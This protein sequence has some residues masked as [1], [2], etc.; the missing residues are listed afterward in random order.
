MRARIPDQAGYVERDSVRTYYEVFGQGE[1]AVVLLPTWS[2]IHSR[3][4]KFQVPYL[5]R[6]CKVI[7]FDGRGNGRSDRP[8]E[9]ADYVDREFADDLK[10]VLLATG[11]DQ[12]IL[13]SLSRAANW[14]LLFA[15]EHPD[16]VSGLVFIGPAVPIPISHPERAVTARFKEELPTSEGWAKYNRYYWLKDHRGFLEYFFG[17]MFNE[18]HSTKQI[19]DCVKWGLETT[20]ATLV[21]TEEAQRIGLKELEALAEQIQCPVLVIHGEDDKIIPHARGAALAK[22][23]K[24][25]LKTVEES[26]HGVMARKPVRVN[27]LLRDFITPA[28]PAAPVPLPPTGPIRKNSRRRAKRALFISSPIGLGHA[29]RDIAI[30]D[31]LRLLRPDLE[32]EWLA[33]PPVTTAL[34]A[35]GEKIHPASK[36][37]ACE[38]AHI[39][40]E[41]AEHDLHCFQAWRQMDE[42][43]LANFMVFHDLVRE[44]PF[45]LWI[46]DEAWEL[47]YYLHEN[48][49]QKKAPYVWL[50]D[51]VGWLPMPDGG[52]REE[53]LTADYN[54]E[55]VGHIARYPQLRDLALFVGN[56][57]D[58]IPDRF[59]PDLPLIRDWT[60]DHYEFPGYITGFQP[61]APSE[62]EELRRELGYRPDEKVCLVTVGGSGVGHH[63]LKRV[64]AAFPTAKRSLPELR[65]IV[66][67]GPRIDPASLPVMPGLEV[68]GYVNGLY[69]HLAAADLAVVQGGLSTAME[70]TANQRPFL[71]FP[72]KHHFEQNYHVRYRLDRYGA[73][74]PMDYEATTP[75]SL[76]QAM[77]NELK[78]PVNYR[79]VESDGAARAARKIAELL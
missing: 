23:L 4:W 69:R 20:P 51:F 12:A 28:Q 64:I 3:I 77:L 57:G 74:C 34:Q 9:A 42:I 6:H 32:I 46:G 31:E 29:W 71:Y 62:R 40:S 73:G 72:L 63:L 39:E 22:M 15:A 61:I 68:R 19:E 49:E 7:T 24:G 21:A 78:R 67:C 33:Q 65:M 37:L 30:A 26:G 59:G 76:A 8:P 35:H 18:L 17:Q 10:A 70:L 38:V 60:E 2:I 50:T 25:D 36:F 11:T 53:Y 41:S 56:A 45:D 79:P 13:V 16:L 47:D 14:A 27:L 52:A 44:E 58:I 48:P 1:P 54:S 43:L 75:E 66:V 5:Y 55:M